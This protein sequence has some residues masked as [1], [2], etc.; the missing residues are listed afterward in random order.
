M[1]IN[2]NY[3]PPGVQV[4][5]DVST[6]VAPLIA[7]SDTICL[8][9]FASGTILRTETVRLTNTTVTA[10]P[11]LANNK[12][13][14]N[15][16]IV[17]V[18]S[19]DP[20]QT[21]K[22]TNNPS[23]LLGATE[24]DA[25]NTTITL[26][27]GGPAALGYT[28]SGGAPG[29]IVIDNEQI[30]YTGTSG[31]NLTGCVRGANGTIATTHAAG[32]VVNTYDVSKGYAASTYNFYAD[33]I[34]AK[35]DGDITATASS[36]VIDNG[37]L[38]GN[39]LTSIDKFPTE[40]VITVGNEQIYYTAATFNGTGNKFTLTVA[41]RGYNGTIPTNH[42]DNDDVTI[43]TK[44]SIARVPK[45]YA[46]IGVATIPNNTYI[47]V[48]YKYEPSDYWTPQ[49]F[50]NVS[51]IEERYGSKFTNDESRVL[52]PL[53]LAAQIAFENGATEVVVQPVFYNNSGTKQE[54][55]GS[56]FTDASKTWQPTLE[57]LRDLTGIGTIVPVIGQGPNPVDVSVSFNDNNVLAVFQEVQ[58]H[59][60]YQRENNDEYIIAVLGE[61]GTDL[62]A[63]PAYAT[64]T[65][66][67]N[68]GNL[69]QSRLL[70]SYN[71][72]LILLSKSK[73]KRFKST[74]SGEI[75]LGAQYVAAAIAGMIASRPVSSTLTRKNIAG[76]SSIN[77]PRTKQE[78]NDDSA[79]GL[80]VLEQKGYAI[81]VRHA[82]T[83]DTTSVARSEISVV[84]AKHKVIN[85]LRLTID[86]QIV[87]QIVAD[88]N[89]PLI[90]ASAI[91]NTLSTLQQDNDI[92]SFANVQAQIKS[93]DP[94]LI[95]VAFSYRPAFPVNH[96]NIVFSID[97]SSGSLTTNETDRTNSGALNG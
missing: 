21:L 30:T 33:D 61:D 68:H 63:S 84:R 74:G 90:V 92:V 88:N 4:S 11:T 43:Q 12:D 9:G 7:T 17:S 49:K 19:G 27:A 64:S 24:L 80:L 2:Y 60:K 44:Y 48:T 72:Q 8:I 35:L 69:L 77:H 29:T 56:Q 73:F 46:N 13:A 58:N 59:V 10:L 71:E 37:V 3:L 23:T 20:S 75:D 53:S 47:N 1:S 79:N 50:K 15:V 83:L 25:S 66:I 36:I 96:I 28:A 22:T 57:S 14:K 89:A 65:V 16:S 97:L 62:N 26:V 95:E 51:A 52:S 94:T 31:N 38:S 42:T 45:T 87:G 41:T 32:S 93:L 40:G 91:S 85:S 54:P 82:L 6:S 34:K 70:G 39:N 86:S 67:R 5:E 81:Q 55:V 76:F 18:V 78:N